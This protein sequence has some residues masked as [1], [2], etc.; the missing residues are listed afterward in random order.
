MV[1][2]WNVAA[3]VIPLV[4]AVISALVLREQRMLRA[5]EAEAQVERRTQDVKYVADWLALDMKRVYITEPDSVGYE[6]RRMF[7]FGNIKGKSEILFSLKDLRNGRD[8][9][10]SEM[11]LQE[12]E[13]ED[14][15]GDLYD[16]AEVSEIHGSSRLLLNL[17]TADPDLIDDVA[18]YLPY[19]LLGHGEQSES[20]EDLLKRQT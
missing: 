16:D 1:S 15:L 20:Y 10:L 12:D 7:L 14:L 11:E 13:L 9:D 5:D 6:L 4:G 18:R 17:N 19:H 3:I 8:A 2:P